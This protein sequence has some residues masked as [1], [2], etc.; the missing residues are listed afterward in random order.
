MTHTHVYDTQSVHH[1]KEFSEIN[2]PLLEHLISVRENRCMLMCTSGVASILRRT[3][4]GRR[5]YVSLGLG[6]GGCRT[7]RRERGA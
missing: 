7:G 2:H 3:R 4:T 1:F 5:G 6:G